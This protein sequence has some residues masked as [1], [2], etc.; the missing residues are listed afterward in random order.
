MTETI[1]AANK[2]IFLFLN[3]KHGSAKYMSF[4]L[5]RDFS[6]KFDVLRLKFKFSRCD[7]RI[8]VSTWTR[9]STRSPCHL[10]NT[11]NLT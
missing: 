3:V 7:Y 9:G 5:F 2:K 4:F 11:L 6:F 8:T 1:T 10:H